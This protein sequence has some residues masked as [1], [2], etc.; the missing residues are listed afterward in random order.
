MTEFYMF[1]ILSMVDP[2]FTFGLDQSPIGR[3]DYFKIWDKNNLKLKMYL[4]IFPVA[5]SD[6]ADSGRMTE[7]RQ[8]GKGSMVTSIIG[9]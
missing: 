7:A 9:T 4:F 6:A 2:E 3:G 8:Y 1:Y 5:S